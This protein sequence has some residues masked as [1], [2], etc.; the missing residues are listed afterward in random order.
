MEL[1]ASE[2]R[3]AGSLIPVRLL[4]MSKSS[5]YVTNGN[6]TKAAITRIA[7]ICIMSK[8]NPSSFSS[9]EVYL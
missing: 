8:I 7:N 1:I 2:G 5:G 6:S 4:S 9:Q 3:P